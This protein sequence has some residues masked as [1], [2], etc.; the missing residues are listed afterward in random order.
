VMVLLALYAGVMTLMPSMVLKIR[1]G[2]GRHPSG[3]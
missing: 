1:T 3:T 2:W